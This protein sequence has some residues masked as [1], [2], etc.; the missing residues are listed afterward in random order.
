MPDAFLANQISAF[1]SLAPDTENMGGSGRQAGER[2]GK[3]KKK[4]HETFLIPPNR[5]GFEC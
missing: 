5:C 1:L 2:E 4:I 3:K